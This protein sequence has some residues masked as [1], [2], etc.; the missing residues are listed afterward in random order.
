MYK[1]KGE[2]MGYNYIP[3]EEMKGLVDVNEA[4]TSRNIY[5]DLFLSRITEV[6][7]VVDDK[8]H[9]I[10]VVTPSDLDKL[11]YN[12]D[13]GLEDVVNKNCYT[14]DSVDF[15]K[16]EIFFLKYNGQRPFTICI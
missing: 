1:R 12:D 2:Y 6:I 16:A 8:R 13:S 5:T 15:R 9:L 14:L 11:Y 4:K 7:Y 10:G 3:Y